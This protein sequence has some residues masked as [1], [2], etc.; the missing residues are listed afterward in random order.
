[1]TPA[2]PAVPDLFEPERALLGNL[3]HQEAEPARRLLDGL[4]ARDFSSPLAV[5]ALR[6]VLDITTAG[7]APTPVAVFDQARETI[8]ELA[9]GGGRAINLARLGRWLLD[10][11]GEA[12]TPCE[13]HIG[14]LKA[15]V[16]KHAWRRA[17]AEHAT[18]VLQASQECSSTELH[19]IATDTRQLEQLWR[20]YRAA[21]DGDNTGHDPRAGQAPDLATNWRDAA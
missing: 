10:A 14:W 18:R 9:A 5:L 13:E 16:C 12:S 3:M 1:M 17:V 4:D 20:R 21:A 2:I 19:R 6:L 8:G 11:Y 7:V 15:I